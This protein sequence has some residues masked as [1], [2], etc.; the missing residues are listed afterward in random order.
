MQNDLQ[1]GEGTTLQTLP[2]NETL[3]ADIA[4]LQAANTSTLI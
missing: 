3:Q 1:P 2:V 4:F